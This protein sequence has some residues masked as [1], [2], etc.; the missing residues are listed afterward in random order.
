[1]H[2]LNSRRAPETDITQYVC[3][4]GIS[5]GDSPPKPNRHSVFQSIFPCSSANTGTV[6]GQPYP[7]GPRPN[8]AVH[9]RLD[10][11]GLAVDP[12]RDGGGVLSMTTSGP[13]GS[14]AIGGVLPAQQL[15][16]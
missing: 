6:A 16:A 15:T 3:I 13:P 7:E 11:D 14:W 5:L 8:G 1:M 4:V 2:C 9:G 10:G 12:D